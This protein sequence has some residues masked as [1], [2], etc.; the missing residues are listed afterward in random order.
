MSDQTANDVTALTTNS[1][2]RTGYT[3]GGWASSAANAT[4]GT[5]AYANG[6]NYDFLATTTL[7]AIW[8]ANSNGGSGS[9]STS[10]VSTA[11]ANTGSPVLPNL[12]SGLAVILLGV[13][14]IVR[15]KRLER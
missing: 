3:F 15:Q 9:S 5:V 1:F 10:A 8:T 6:A 4:A 13:I 12:L 2:T 14:I 7:Y 11:L